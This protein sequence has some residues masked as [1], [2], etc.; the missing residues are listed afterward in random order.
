ML[1]GRASKN[2]KAEINVLAVKI[3]RLR[4]KLLSYGWSGL[5][6]KTLIMT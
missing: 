4:K 5:E 6:V 3:T 2:V 1:P